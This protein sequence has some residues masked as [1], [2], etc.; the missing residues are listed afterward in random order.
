MFLSDFS[1]R[2]PVAA[3]V[4][5]VSLVVFGIIGLNRLGISLFP[6]VDFPMVTVSTV[7][8]NAR[9]EEVDNEITDELEDAVSTVSEIKH[10]I[11]QSM[12]GRSRITVEF[13]LTKDIDVAA[14]EIRDKVSARIYKLP[15]DAETPVIDKLDIN[16]Q[17]I[18]WLAVTGPYAIEELT[19]IAD[20]QIRP[21][22]QKIQGVGEVR[23]GGGREKEVQ[24]WLHRE[25]LA[26]Y[27]IGVDEVVEAVRRQ[28]IEI[29]GGKIESSKK[30]FLIRTLGE[31]ESPEA[32][33]DLI[34]AYRHGMPIRIRNLGYAEAGREEGMAVA[35]FTHG[36]GT[37]RGVG[38][39]V[40]PRSGANEVA[41]AQR[42]RA[43]LPQIRSQIPAGMAI[44]I[45]ND[46]TQFIEESIAEIK[47][48]LLAG[49]IMAALV[50][51]LFLQNLRTTLISGLAI[52]TSIVA[53]FA[54]IYFMGYTLN[55]MTMLAL[56][57][58]VGLVIDDAIVMVEN[59]FRHRFSLG[60]SSMQAAYEG[61]SEIAFAVVAATAALAGV[62]IPVAFMGGM[63]GR[64][65]L[66]FAVTMA[67]AIACS[68][69]VALTVIPMLCSRFLTPA[70][71][72]SRVFH[73]FNWMMSGLS[74]L[75]RRLLAWFLAHRLVVL[76]LAAAS[77]VLGGYMFTLVG[78]E[79]I[80]AEDQSRF[81]IRVE[82]PLSYSIDK[83]DEVMQRLESK[84][85]PIQEIQS[86][87]SIAGL[88]GGGVVDSNKG[89]AFVTMVP[90]E[91]RT[92]TQ[93]DVQSQVRAMLREIPDLGGGVTDI[94]PLGGA[95]RNEDI[96]LVIQGP[97]IAAIDR[98][99][100]EIMDA[101][102]GKGGYVG[103]T[104]DLELGKPEVRV[105]IDREKAAD[106]GVS[107]QT[108]AASVGALLGGRDLTP[109][110]YK[111]GGKSYDIRLRLVREERLLPQDVQ[112]I[113]VRG[114]NGDV[115]DIGN[116]VRLETGVGPNVINRMDRQRSATVYANLEGKLMADAMEEVRAV[117]E[118]VLPD[119]Y[120]YKFTGRA[121]AF[122][123]TLGYIAFAFVLS[124]VLTY[125]V[126]AAQFE[127]FVQPFSIMA[128]LPLSFIGAF[129]LLLLLDNTLNL[130]SMI[131]MVLLVGLVTKNG[132]LLV[133][134]T[135]QLRGKGVPVHE[136]LV[137]AGATRLRPILMTAVSTIAGVIPVAL[138]IG[139]GSES[140]QPLA[141]AIA[142]GMISSTFLTL[143]VV[144]V[145][146]S[147]LDQA[148]NW[149]IL[150]AITGRIMA[151]EDQKGG[152]G[153]LKSPH[154]Y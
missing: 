135:N 55:N 108:I 53:T 93:R 10:I 145:L 21:L 80:T 113:W 75:Y 58:A 37:E 120:T 89:I 144:P 100:K 83:M 103:I 104:R 19:R 133:D 119:G 27:R 110:T 136:A 153:R 148:A 1:I 52:P 74:R 42:V 68:L 49:G 94:S 62:F 154:S 124:T 84:L 112:R 41:I 20:E 127:S 152:E 97:D 79:F 26:A 33:N 90:K 50:I 15:R 54:C 71:D 18:I 39:G 51:L 86:F 6:D 130:F 106:A 64:F 59:I 134:Y 107:V 77:L 34:V 138:G 32:F 60:K 147:F 66:Q 125:L 82:A 126:L 142:G 36:G 46:N 109:A 48:Q 102:Q 61:S 99:S 140:R 78:K 111:E 9:P 143:G 70:K 35:R 25:E 88:G 118:E 151:Q 47:F 149:R 92:R 43:S 146:Y 23:V 122:S 17:P 115:M 131:A 40:S 117:A 4:M 96:Q 30:E 7:W 28:H 73:V 150:K 132:I 5:I 31:F 81:L 44:Q 123:E 57:T 116:F 101:L 85:R 137:E 65:F 22:L 11:S 56:V 95:S 141:V 76:V 121:E 24:I 72:D 87:F 114:K 91:E 12:Q 45:T 128:G 105:H 129:G 69:L 38:M 2:R 14:Q 13:D 139:V 29:P 63:V 8:Q 16:A 98:H 67:F 3:T